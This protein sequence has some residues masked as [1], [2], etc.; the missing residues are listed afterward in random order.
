ME[1]YYLFI[2]IVLVILAIVDLTVGVA[3]DAANFLNSA[4]GSQVSSRWLILGVASLG[5]LVGTLTSSGMMEIARSGVF[6][7]AMF[8]FHDVM[9]IFIAVM[10]CDVLL[11]DMYNTF[12]LPTSTTVSL[13]FELLGA[14]VFVAL[15]KIWTSPPDAVGI[16][17]NYINTAKA[18]E[19]I[20]AILASVVIAFI[21]GSIIMFISRI[22]FTFRYKR[23]LIKF[24]AMWGGLCLTA[25]VYFA[26]FKGLKNSTIVSKDVIHLIS[27]NIGFSLL[28]CFV[29][30]TGLMALLQFLFRVSILKIIVLTGTGALALAF[31]GNDLVNFI[32]VTMAGISSYEIASDYAASGGS[33][34]A[35][36]MGALAKPVSV[37][38]FYLFAAGVVMILALWFS[39]KV[40]TVTQTGVNL[41]R[42]EEGIERFGSTPASRALV[43]ST[44][45]L[46]KKVT[47]R[48]PGSVNR[49]ID[50]RFKPWKVPKKNQASFDL[51]R[52]S[53]NLTVAALLIS[54]AT[55]FTLPLSTTYV[56]FMVAM[57]TSLSD[58]AWGRES[59]V[60]RISGV[61]TVVT[62]WFLTALVA[63]SA[64]AIVA[65]LLMWG[66]KISLTVL[67]AVC[68][69]LLVQSSRLH[70]KRKKKQVEVEESPVDVK[71]SAIV[72]KCKEDVY[73]VFEQIT[74]VYSETLNGLASEDP[75]RLKKLY[76]EAKELYELEKGRRNYEMLPTL[77]K[78]QEDAV[79]TGHYYVQVVSYL[80]EASKSLMNITKSSF[81]YIDNNHK[82]L[83][84][85]QLT[86][87]ENLTQEVS[88]VYEGIVNMLRTSDFS[89][90][91]RILAKRDNVFDLFVD[92]IK[93]QIKR[94]KEK[95]SSTRNSILFL[96][97]VNETK[98]MVLQARN[99]MK[100]QRLFVGFEEGQKAIS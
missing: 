56:T 52:A 33:I 13:I 81:E 80:Y 88:S 12:G 53:V 73:R 17:V 92:N 70:K 1:N 43:R 39:K 15:Y 95:E 78:L 14:A 38:T 47:A 58:R 22:I 54:I 26:I 84:E 24:G 44:R 41:S 87:L 96:D 19:M 75:K 45:A 85:N 94:V 97:L 59:A 83:S 34:D 21:S 93:A 79:N 7:P 35:M 8:T 49:F 16:L 27:S 18:L 61:L 90:F 29:S 99:L 46:H 86:D 20:T 23:S 40:R 2:I 74:R 31:A 69:L 55:S 6:H 91:E 28:I 50:S 9:M 68:V 25:I 36:T 100:A 82:G 30:L 5:V 62:G 10:I 64:A 71:K 51:I 67:L 32:G 57:G 63:F 11:L 4:V 76:K 89:D 3:N 77:L 72:E 65:I 48:M 66:G 42:Q 37:N 60:Y 98:A